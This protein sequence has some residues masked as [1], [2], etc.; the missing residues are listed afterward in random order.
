MKGGGCGS[1]RVGNGPQTVADSRN[2]YNWHSIQGYFYEFP[3]EVI[4]I[5]VVTKKDN[6]E[7]GAGSKFW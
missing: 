7:E 6:G 4:I 5:A 2:S 1:L 3:M